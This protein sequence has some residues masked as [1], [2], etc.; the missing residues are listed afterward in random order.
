MTWKEAESLL[1]K[2]MDKKIK[3]CFIN[4]QGRFKREIFVIYE[5][6][7]REGI[8][9]FNPTKYDFVDSEFIG[10]TKLQALYRCDNRKP[11]VSGF[12]GRSSYGRY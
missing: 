4:E 9:H 6:G 12:E 10:L 8:H 1:D 5:D 3:R 7:S 2:N 11:I